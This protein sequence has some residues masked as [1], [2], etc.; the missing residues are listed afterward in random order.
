MTRVKICGITT[1]EDAIACTEAGADAIGMILVKASPRCI[2]A[3]QAA[4]II[5]A[6]P[7]FVSSVLVMTPATPGEA[8]AAAQQAR[9]SALQLQ[10]AESPEVLMAI[11]ARLPGIKL[12][13][14]VHV[15][16]GEEIARARKYEEVADAILLDTAS[17]AGGGMGIAHDWSV[18]E[19]LVGAVQQPVVLAG[20]LNP[21]NVADAIRAVRPYAV[22]VASGV[23]KEKRKK[24]IGLVREF[25]RQAKVMT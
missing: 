19:E 4:E 15:G 9:P 22:D 16:V 3:D 17:P 18:S 23:E 14:T 2:T 1:K 5:L 20:G 11:K 13:K 21:K 10:G 12:I 6:L 24:D 25:I 8:I 7:P